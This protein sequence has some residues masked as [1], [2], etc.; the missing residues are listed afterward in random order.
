MRKSKKEIKYCEICETK[1][2]MDPST[3]T[4]I[5]FCSKKCYSESRKGIYTK[6]YINVL[7]GI[8]LENK[9]YSIAFCTRKQLIEKLKQLESFGIKKVIVTFK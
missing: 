9:I 2:N 7:G 8:N 1:L 4:Q 3:Q 6:G 5:R